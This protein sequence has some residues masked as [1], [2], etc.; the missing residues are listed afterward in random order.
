MKYNIAVKKLKFN[1][2]EILWKVLCGSLSADK[3]GH[4]HFFFKPFFNTLETFHC[5]GQILYTSTEC[6]QLLVAPVCQCKIVYFLPPVI[7]TTRGQALYSNAINFTTMYPPPLKQT[8]LYSPSLQYATP[9]SH[10]L[11]YTLPYF[12]TLRY[13]KHTHTTLQVVLYSSKFNDNTL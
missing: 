1:R 3:L 9:Y 8:S 2:R 4:G 13:T 12:P 7:Y 6:L 11:H 10:L 5:L